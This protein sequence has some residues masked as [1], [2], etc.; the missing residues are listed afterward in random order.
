MKE[1][2]FYEYLILGLS[3]SLFLVLY[4]IYAGSSAHITAPNLVIK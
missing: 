2:Q 1:H 4:G 3:A